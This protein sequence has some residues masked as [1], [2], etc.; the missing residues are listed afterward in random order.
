M[1]GTRRLLPDVCPE[2]ERVF[3]DTLGFSQLTPVQAATIPRFLAHCDV[4]VEACTGSGK[5]LAFVLPVCELLRRRDDGPARAPGQ[6]GAVIV[7]PTRELAA[8]ILLSAYLESGAA[9]R[10]DTLG[11]DDD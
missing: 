10:S 8:Q 7:S 9:G 2:L 4:A 1:A 5:T 3:T 6:W 11:L